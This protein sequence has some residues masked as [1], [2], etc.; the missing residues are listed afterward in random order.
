MKKLIIFDCDGV[1]VDSEIISNRINAEALTRLG[2]SITAEEMAKKFV[3]VDSKTAKE[4]ILSEAKIEL[5][6]NMAEFAKQEII[7]ACKLELKPLL[8]EFVKELSLKNISRCV[9]SNNSRERVLSSLEITN[10]LQFFQQ[11]HI[12]AA[13]QVAKGKPDSALFHLAAKE[14]G[15]EVQ[16][17]IVIEDSKAGINGAL[18]ASMKVFGFLGGTHAKYDWYQM[19]IKELN[20]TL[21]NNEEELRRLISLL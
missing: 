19:R 15:Y 13:S 12:F 16:D 6:E 21:A 3:G 9:V 11:E 18:A 4:L 7:E 1:L 8:F 14:L 10:Q 17:C 2:Y 20:I 5:P